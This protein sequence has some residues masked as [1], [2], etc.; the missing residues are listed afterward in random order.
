LPIARASIAGRFGLR[1]PVDEQG[2]FLLEPGA[3]FVTL[4]L[5]GMLRGC[6]GS[7]RPSRPLLHDVKANAQA[8]AFEDPRFRPLDAGEL[9]VTRIEV[10]VLSPLAQIAFTAEDEAAAALRPFEDGVVLVWRE[11]RGTFLPQLWET[12]PQPCTFLRQLKRKS[13]LAADFWADDIELYRY[14]VDKWSEPS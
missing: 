7:L 12:F 11:M 13:G 8:A 3:S 10:S 14:T 5:E 4:R 2:D 6:I 9:S 1:F